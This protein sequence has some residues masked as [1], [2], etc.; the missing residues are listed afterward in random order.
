MRGLRC[1][2]DWAQGDCVRPPKFASLLQALPGHSQEPLTVPS[3]S[4]AG[5]G[6]AVRRAAPAHAPQALSLSE[7][8]LGQAPGHKAQ[9]PAPLHRACEEDP[10]FLLS[11]LRGTTQEAT[12]T[13]T[14]LCF[15]GALARPCGHV[16]VL[17]FRPDAGSEQCTAGLPPR[18]NPEE[19]KAQPSRNSEK[20]PSPTGGG[21]HGVAH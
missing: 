8:V 9:S 3:G 19:R 13:N 17:R 18:R 16:R 21:G 6:L 11:S 2:P 10:L 12:R 1:S 20:T 7:E 15:S 4:R 5:L 14:G